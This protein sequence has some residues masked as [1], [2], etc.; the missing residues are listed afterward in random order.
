[1]PGPGNGP[2]VGRLLEAEGGVSPG[3]ASVSSE[4]G[5]RSPAD[6]RMGPLKKVGGEGTQ[7]GLGEGGQNRGLGVITGPAARAPGGWGHR[8]VSSIHPQCPRGRHGRGPRAGLLPRGTA[9]SEK[10]LGLSVSRGV[11]LR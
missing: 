11:V 9:V 6:Q 4:V 2:E 7:E 3:A 8:W 10:G 1:M 5:N